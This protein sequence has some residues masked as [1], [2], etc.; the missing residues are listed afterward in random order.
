MAIEKN[1]LYGLLSAGLFG[2]CYT[3]DKSIVGRTDLNIFVYIF[4]SYPLVAF[5]AFLVNPNEIIGALKS[6]SVADF[7]PIIISAAAYL[8][9]NVFTFMA[10]AYDAEVGKVDAINNSQ[11]FLI[12]L[13][14]YFVLKHSRG[15]R[16]KLLAAA[17]A[18]CGVFIL[19]FY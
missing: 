13:F 3:L 11:V 18:Y 16:R 19:G 4:W 17:V 5:W 1:H 8:M 7:K 10:Y 6:K 9:F 2:I 12:I 15:W 14:E